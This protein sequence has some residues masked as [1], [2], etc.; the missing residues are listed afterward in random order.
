M[1]AVV[2]TWIQKIGEKLNIVIQYS[3]RLYGLLIN[4]AN[5][6]RR[7]VRL[8]SGTVPK[9]RFL[10]LEWEFQ[11]EHSE[12]EVAAMSREIEQFKVQVITLQA[13]KSS[14]KQEV[15]KLESEKQSLQRKTVVLSDRLRKSPLATA[16]HTRSRSLKP[17]DDY[18]ESHKR[19]LK[20]TRAQT[21]ELSLS[22]L[23]K[24]GLIP[25]SVQVHNR[26]SG[27]T[28]TVSL[29]QSD[30][31]SLFGPGDDTSEDNLAIINMLLFVKDWYNISGEA[32]HELASICKALPRHY[33]I[34]QRIAELNRLWNIKRTPYGIIGLQQSLEDRLQ[35]RLTHLLRVSK[36]DAAF[37]QEKVLHVKL[38]GDG[39]N[40][41]KRL[42]VINFTFTLLE[43]GPL[44]HSCHG[45]HILVV[46]KEAEKYE[47]LK[48]GLSDIRAEVENLKTLE[49]NGIKFGRTYYLGGGL[50]FL[51]IVTG[52][53]SASSKYA[54]IWCKERNYERY[55]AD[56]QW[57]ISNSQKGARS[58]EE[59]IEIAQLPRSR[60]T[61][62]VSNFFQPSPSLML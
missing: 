8:C 11:L 27:K 1:A 17:F 51:A 56:R 38:S 42:H 20:R 57:S 45:N 39:T 40:I 60:K 29:S 44:A 13:P 32:Y 22:W 48:N 24:E 49:Q 26:E 62:N 16:N 9:K 35:I 50:K 5:Y 2:R 33:G 7:K 23:E 59:N 36:S 54:C 14:M 19:R 30:T 47:S 41:G 3:E 4:R 58:I 55:D 52:V 43:E 46:L 15:N 34:K 10:Q 31:I 28:E 12:V 18:S 21:C 6:I 53:D 61:Y 25:I 37:R